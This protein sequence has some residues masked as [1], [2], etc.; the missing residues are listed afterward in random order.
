MTAPAPGLFS[1]T[2]GWPMR[3]ETPSAAAR[4]MRSFAPPGA[5]GTIQRTGRSGHSAC[6]PSV[7]KARTAK[8][9]RAIEP[10][11]IS[12]REA[13]ISPWKGLTTPL[14]H[15]SIRPSRFTR[16]S[17]SD[18]HESHLQ[19]TA[20]PGALRARFPHG[21]GYREPSRRKTAA[22]REEP[23]ID[24]IIAS[25]EFPAKPGEPKRPPGFLFADSEERTKNGADDE[26]DDPE[27]GMAAPH[28]GAAVEAEKGAARFR[29]VRSRRAAGNSRADRER[30]RP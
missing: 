18:F 23:G 8:S 2:T 15:G 13:S 3:F 14:L 24:L 9:M 22:L 16:E 21:V 11:K 20:D 28:A 12:C 17:A 25:E 27:A 26:R 7:A 5:N 6:A 19:S 4:A 30:P 10:M 29:A 1:I